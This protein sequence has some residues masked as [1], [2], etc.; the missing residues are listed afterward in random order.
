MAVSEDEQRMKAPN[1]VRNSAYDE[2]MFTMK[3]GLHDH[4]P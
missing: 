4:R 2:A 1:A 3:G